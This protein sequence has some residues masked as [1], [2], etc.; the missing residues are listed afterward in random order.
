MN[1]DRVVYI[2]TFSPVAAG[3]LL[4]GRFE[5][6]VKSEMKKEKGQADEHQ[7][8][9]QQKRFLIFLVLKKKMLKNLK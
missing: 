8:Q 9:Q 5:S 2:S 6:K 7:Q 4:V 1:N 3:L